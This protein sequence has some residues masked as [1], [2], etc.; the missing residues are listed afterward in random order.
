MR[1]CPRCGRVFPEVRGA[2]EQ[3]CPSC[4]HVFPSD[5]PPA[6]QAP[7]PAEARVDPVAALGLA[8]R[9]AVRR[10][11]ALLLAWAP[12]VLVDFGVGLL[13]ERTL[14]ADASALGVQA[15][16]RLLGIVLPPLLL[17]G[18][19]EMAGWGL[20]SAAAFG[21]ARDVLPRLGALLLLGLLLTATFVAGFLLLVV[22]FFVFLHWFAYAPAALA[23]GR[24][25][26]QAF[27]ASRAF[28]KQRRAYGFT[29]LIVLAWLVAAGATFALAAALAPLLAGLGLGPAAVAALGGAL[30][31]WP[32]APLVPLLPASYW[33]L[34]SRAPAAE[35]APKA[36]PGPRATTTCPKC[37]TLFP[38][39]RAGGP[40]DVT[41][42]SCGNRGRVL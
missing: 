11:P 41:C 9:T 19:A 7:P 27:E 38:F 14:P 13:V 28:A 10:Y 42:P 23:E 40:V 24:T 30:A 29:V 26:G 22:P 32:F 39:E 37:G 33:R 16:L 1:P 20:V 15:Q 5:A 12:L 35:T 17:L 21:R 36:A 2:P 31:A 25:V 18:A 34:A 3:A 6:G 4:G 8:A